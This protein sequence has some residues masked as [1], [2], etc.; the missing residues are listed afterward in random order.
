MTDLRDIPNPWPKVNPRI[1]NA[2]LV[3][4]RLEEL[5]KQGVY[6]DDKIL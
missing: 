6:F 5:A 2:Q 3:P 1:F 4:K